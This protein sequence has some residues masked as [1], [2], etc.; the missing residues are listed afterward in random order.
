MSG[1]AVI[2]PF[3]MSLWSFAIFSGGFVIQ[4]ERW[5]GTIEYLVAAPVGFAWIIVGRIS[6]MMVAG[7]ASF[8]EIW[9]FGRYVMRASV[10][11]HHPYLFAASLSLTLLAMAATALFM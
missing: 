6:T 10:T 2:A 9:L 1:F 5:G 4:S 8:G 3:Y 11:I 7:A